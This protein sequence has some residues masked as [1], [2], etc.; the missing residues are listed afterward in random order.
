MHAPKLGAHLLHSEKEAPGAPFSLAWS[1]K[2]RGMTFR[3]PSI[4]RIQKKGKMESFLFE[5]HSDPPQVN[6]E[7][8]DKGNGLLHSTSCWMGDS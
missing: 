4:I 5:L 3:N 6:P 8:S 7:N 2:E 1:A